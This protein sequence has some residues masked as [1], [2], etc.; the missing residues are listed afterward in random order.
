MHL[1]F[2]WIKSMWMYNKIFM[3]KIDIFKHLCDTV[4]SWG[5]AALA[6][7]QE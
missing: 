1:S 2:S 6:G 4:L 5:I 3:Q 7:P